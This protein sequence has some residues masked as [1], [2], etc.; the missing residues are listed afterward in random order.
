MFEKFTFKLG[1]YSL[2]YK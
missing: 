2:E 1:Q